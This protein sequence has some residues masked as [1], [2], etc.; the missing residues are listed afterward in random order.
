MR[1]PQV[2]EPG[3][4]RELTRILRHN[5]H[6]VWRGSPEVGRCFAAI[7]RLVG[8]DRATATLGARLA[9]LVNELLVCVLETLRSQHV[10]QR[11][12]LASAERTTEM[13]LQELAASLDQPWT[14][15]AMAE[16]TGLKR[17][18]FIHYVRRLTNRS[19]I[20]H[21]GHLRV[22]HA[23]A[24]MAADPARTLTELALACG[25]ANGQYFATTFRR[26]TGLSP[27]EWRQRRAR[28]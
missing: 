3:D 11:A 24:L 2:L 14:V 22:E 7:G 21:L 5:E 9:L 28:N 6:P 15:D 20:E 27:R 18:R 12:S 4:L 23:K 19:P 8:Q 26:H 10:P 16:S 25:F 17:T 13:F 1:P